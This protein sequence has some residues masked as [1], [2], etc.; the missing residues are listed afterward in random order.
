MKIKLL[1]LLFSLTIILPP[2]SNFLF[3]FHYEFS[4]SMYNGTWAEEKYV[5]KKSSDVNVRTLTRDEII[6]TFKLSK[7][8]IPYGTKNL[9]IICK[10]DSEIKSI[11]RIGLMPVTFKCEYN[12]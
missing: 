12:E 3:E 11:E 7:Y 8:F 5:I 10:Y 4:W 2:S 1:N 9:K 6:K